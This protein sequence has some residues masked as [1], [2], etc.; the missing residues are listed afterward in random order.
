MFISMPLIFGTLP[1]MPFDS[2]S[3]LIQ[4]AIGLSALFMPIFFLIRAY[5]T[6]IY[7]ELRTPSAYIITG[8]FLVGSVLLYGF[9][10]D[11]TGRIFY[12]ILSPFLL[13]MFLLEHVLTKK[14]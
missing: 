2:S 14:R 7:G 6:A 13:C 12:G 9:I 11:Y 4:G 1:D 8:L 5:K 10:L 3:K